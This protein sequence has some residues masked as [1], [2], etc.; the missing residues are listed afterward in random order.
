M[1]PP[2]RGTFRRGQIWDVDFEPQVGAEIS[3]IRPAV[4]INIAKVG[5]L[6][7]RIVVP[8]TTGSDSLRDA[9]WTVDI[10]ADRE[11]GLTRDSVADTFQVKSLSLNRFVRQRGVLSAE[12]LKEVADRIAY[13]VGFVAR[14][15]ETD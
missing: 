10:P 8:I 5:R 4:V 6:P 11:N 1:S 7:L 12:L 15:G 9:P 14:L 13:C 3:K 2:S